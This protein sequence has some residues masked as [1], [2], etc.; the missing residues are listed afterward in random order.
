M[1]GAREISEWSGSKP[2]AEIP[3]LLRN[4]RRLLRAGRARHREAKARAIQPP[5][6]SSSNKSAGL[7]GSSPIRIRAQPTESPTS[8]KRKLQL[9]TLLRAVETSRRR[10]ASLRVQSEIR[11]HPLWIELSLGFWKKN[12]SK[13]AVRP[14]F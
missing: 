13:L 11:N 6:K 10:E 14:K 5:H 4:V 3:T 2:R 12:W 1:R 8:Q 7:H 9:R